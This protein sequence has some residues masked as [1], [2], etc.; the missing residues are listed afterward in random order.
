[1]KHSARNEKLKAIRCEAAIN[2]KVDFSR[3]LNSS[4]VSVFQST[5]IYFLV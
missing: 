2:M 3:E 4:V 5:E 1:M